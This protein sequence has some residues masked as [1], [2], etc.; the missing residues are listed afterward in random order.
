MTSGAKTKL[1][2]ADNAR[3]RTA[4]TSRVKPTVRPATPQT[5]GAKAA[6]NSDIGCRA[7]ETGSKEPLKLRIWHL[8]LTALRNAVQCRFGFVNGVALSWS[9]QSHAIS[10]I[11]KA[12]VAKHPEV[13]DHAG[14]LV[15]GPPGTAEL[16]F[17]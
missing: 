15:N 5:G 1:K 10:R 2:G 8:T 13:F 17:S 7:G 6:R 11:K 4:G 12:G 9:Q 16:P 14:L 3:T